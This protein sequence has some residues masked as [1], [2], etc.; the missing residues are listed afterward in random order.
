M[1]WTVATL[2]FTQKTY[3]QALTVSRLSHHKDMHQNAT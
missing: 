3:V 2:H 1:T